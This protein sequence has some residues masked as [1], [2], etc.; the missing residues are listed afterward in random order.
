[1]S[2]SSERFTQAL[3]KFGKTSTT[4][5]CHN[6]GKLKYF[7]TL[8]VYLLV[9][10][11]ILTLVMAV[12][13]PESSYATTFFVLVI[14]IIIIFVYGVWSTVIRHKP[15]VKLEN[16]WITVA[17]CEVFIDGLGG[18]VVILILIYVPNGVPTLVVLVLCIFLLGY[19]FIIA[20]QLI[21]QIPP[22]TEGRLFYFTRFL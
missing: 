18:I 5:L 3:K 15:E 11:L 16:F 4:E 20:V 7:Q 21:D 2:C 17:I 9:H 12:V 10:I 22:Y 13:D 14:I 1:M 8:W 6:M 19:F